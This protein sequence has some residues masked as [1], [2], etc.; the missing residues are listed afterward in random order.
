M[1]KSQRKKR[2]AGKGTEIGFREHWR[3]QVLTPDRYEG[4][5]MED[6]DNPP[7]PPT[8]E[9]NPE[10]N[11]SDEPPLPDFTD[12]DARAAYMEVLADAIQNDDTEQI[13]ALQSLVGPP[14]G[15]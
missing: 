11:P 8:E 3:G 9:E 7:E 1:S 5:G 13:A 4:G 6:L 14:E 15:E 2:E 10:P 12:P